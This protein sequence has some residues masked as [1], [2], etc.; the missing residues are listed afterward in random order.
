MYNENLILGGNL[1]CDI[2]QWEIFPFQIIGIYVNGLP[3]GTYV[4]VSY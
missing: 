3:K 4:I 1:F 2:L